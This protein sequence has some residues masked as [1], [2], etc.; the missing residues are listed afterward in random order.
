VRRTNRR[1][2]S[3]TFLH[4]SDE[5]DT[6][7]SLQGGADTTLYMDSE[8]IRLCAV[9]ER[10]P[11]LPASPCLWPGVDLRVQPGC[12]STDPEGA[13]TQQRAAIALQGSPY[14]KECWLPLGCGT[15]PL[16]ALQISED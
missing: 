8:D 16:P 5:S 7:Q 14:L 2:R 6:I 4:N 1:S 11:V 3:P 12:E 15:V 10:W 9:T 13:I